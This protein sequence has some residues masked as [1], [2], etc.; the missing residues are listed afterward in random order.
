MFGIAA[1]L[2]ARGNGDDCL[3]ELLDGT[4]RFAMVH[5]TWAKVQED[6]PWPGTVIYPS[7][8]AFVE[9][10]MMPDHQD[11]LAD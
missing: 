6:P 8:Q 3:F 4:A 1:R 7:L 11:W 5:L 9:R 2:I 10:C